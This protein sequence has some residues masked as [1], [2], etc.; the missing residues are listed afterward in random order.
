MS[1]AGAQQPRGPVLPTDL[2]PTRVSKLTS[3]RPASCGGVEGSSPA[4][5]AEGPVVDR[6]VQGKDYRNARPVRCFQ[7]L[8]GLQEVRVIGE[9]RC[10]ALSVIM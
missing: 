6:W 7:T 9:I 4:C 10:G 8:D 1:S 5:R 3:H 2:L